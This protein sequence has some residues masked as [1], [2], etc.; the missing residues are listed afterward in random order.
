MY[1]TVSFKKK[2]LA[3]IVASSTFGLSG[4]AIA[5][6]TDAVEEVV[7]TGIKASLTRSMDLKRDASGVVDAISAEDMGKF[8]DT[9]LAESMQ[10]ITGVS[11]D[12]SGGEGSKVTVRGVGPQGNLVTFNGRSV[13][14]STGDRSFDFANI[15]SELAS[16][17]T[18]A[19]TSSAKLDSGGMGA[20]INVQ[21][22]RPLDHE[23]EKAVVS[24]K[25]IKDDSSKSHSGMTPEA[26]GLYSNTFADNTV[27]VQIA[28]GYQKRD[29][30]ERVA[31]VEDGWHTFDS[32][33]NNDVTGS[34]WGSVPATGQTNRPTTGVYS[35]PQ[36]MRYSFNE[37]ERERT[38]GQLVL[39]WKPTDSIKATLDVDAYQRTVHT[40]K[41]D[42]SAWYTFSQQHAV[43][44]NGP[45]SSPLIYTETYPLSGDGTDTHAN[46][47][48]DYAMASRM[49]YDKFTGNNT[50]LNVQW[51]VSD[52][53]KLAVDASS[54]KADQTP[55][56][57]IAES[58]D[59]Q[60]AA[61][62]RSS[63]SADFSGQIPAMIVGGGNTVKPS[64]MQIVGSWFQNNEAH[65]NIDEYKVSGNFKIDDSNN[66]DFGA[67]SIK[68]H[69][70]NQSVGVQRDDWGGVGQ[71]GDLTS[72][73]TGTDSTILNKFSGSFGDF[74][75][76]SQ[77]PGGNTLADGTVLTKANL[78]NK[79]FAPN[80]FTLQAAANKL[81]NF[82]A[83]I[84]GRVAN[85]MTVGDCGDGAPSIFCASH[86]YDHGT[87]IIVDEKTE[88]FYVQENFKTELGGMPFAA[89]V[90][91]RHEKTTVDSA[92]AS[93]T[94]TG[95]SW[96]A[97]TEIHLA[98][99]AIGYGMQ[100]GTYSYNLPSIDTSL[101]VSDD[102]K[103]RASASK[104]LSR[105][106]YSDLQGGFNVSSG[107]NKGGG[108]GSSGNPALLPL[109]SKNID[110]S[111]EWYFDK[112]SYASLGYFH[113][114]IA[115]YLTTVPV[116]HQLFGILDPTQ[117]TYV[118]QAIAAT[119]TND[120]GIDR[121]WIKNHL[122]GSPGITIDSSGIVHIAGTAGV[123]PPMNFAINTPVNGSDQRTLHGL[124]GAVQYV[125]G[126]S[127]F[128]TSANFTSVVSDLKFDNTLL[129]DQQAILGLSNSYNV[130]GF[131]EKYGVSA[132]LAYNWRDQFLSARGNPRGL[133]PTYTEPFGQLDLNVSYQILENTQIFLQGINIGNEANRQHVR[134]SSAVLSYT[135]TG[136]RWIVG[137]SYTF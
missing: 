37:S 81:Y 122:A 66:I 114:E 84:A 70:H 36:S 40:L 77:L 117:G 13:A 88:A 73:Y 112:S 123:N 8:P 38:N 116:Q 60:A 33:S 7:V 52:R 19:K 34:N 21:S 23:G 86:Q 118:N 47:A 98:T 94:Y 18:V 120:A 15:A 100:E 128:G 78:L 65:A 44:S 32:V 68:A 89:N 24:I 14:G 96:D 67:Q 80:F 124:E 135:E 55:D 62:V 25:G 48:Q 26:F 127:G 136:A 12:R 63:N 59:L 58:A 61:W 106:S 109:V 9:N 115:N 43:F 92:S 11:I 10:R 1:K 130:V 49:Q 53:L 113:K 42:L 29:S 57:K 119:G 41:N 51:D 20:T 4:L 16:N 134:D 71:P 90:G 27:G 121:A 104:S 75:K 99:G 91:L 97:D 22:A 83:E 110:L 54:S 137:A 132:R 6:S 17:V 64:D 50:G 103:V 111:V 131:Y 35:I 69:N 107:A 30:G 45:V 39:Q 3:T 79:F 95:S 2:L 108:S 82:P 87:D 76:A 105:P 93:P 46:G 31:E 28:A 72:I 5:Q 129:A 74:S 56:S 126:D 133:D 101:D 102:V 85:G 125:F